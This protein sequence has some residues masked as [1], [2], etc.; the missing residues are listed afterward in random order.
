MDSGRLTP[1]QARASPDHLPFDP[2]KLSAVRFPDTPPHQ[3]HSVLNWLQR[4]HVTGSCPEVLTC[5]GD[6]EYTRPETLQDG[7]VWAPIAKNPY[8]YGKMP[9]E[10]SFECWK[11]FGPVETQ[12]TVLK[13][14]VCTERHYAADCPYR[15][16]ESLNKSDSPPAGSPE[17]SFREASPVNNDTAPPDQLMGTNGE[18]REAWKSIKTIGW[19]DYLAR[20]EPDQDWASCYTKAEKEAIDSKIASAFNAVEN[21]SPHLKA[22]VRGIADRRNKH[23]AKAPATPYKAPA[24][25]CKDPHSEPRAEAAEP[26]IFLQ[27]NRARELNLQGETLGISNEV[28]AFLHHSLLAKDSLLALAK[29]TNE[30][31]ADG[32]TNLAS[33]VNADWQ[34]CVAFLREIC[35]HP[36]S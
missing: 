6:V 3:M 29:K 32:D 1:P 26:I 25:P 18:L 8:I 20:T 11:R 21:A 14:S 36:H 24:T 31:S 4:N 15:A 17:E 23:S 16:P 5:G 34:D 22:L 13:C 30:A 12:H 7:H 19:Y 33:L 2:S 27:L 10:M 35:E 28:A 9:V